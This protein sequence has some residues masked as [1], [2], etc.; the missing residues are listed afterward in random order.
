MPVSATGEAAAWCRSSAMR[1]MAE[2]AAVAPAPIGLRCDRSRTPRPVLGLHREITMM[3]IDSPGSG[4][5]EFPLRVGAARGSGRCHPRHPSPLAVYALG[6]A[7]AVIHY[8]VAPR[9]LLDAMKPP[10]Y[11][12]AGSHYWAIGRTIQLA[13]GGR[14]A[15]CFVECGTRG[16]AAIPCAEHEIP[17]R[18]LP[19]AGEAIGRDA[20]LGCFL[21]SKLAS[22]GHAE[23]RSSL[24]LLMATPQSEAALSAR[25]RRPS[26]GFSISGLAGHR[27]SMEVLLSPAIGCTGSVTSVY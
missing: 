23:P 22:L 6:T 8:L 2:R 19:S 14:R 20:P 13:R 18:I 25:R 12:E 10:Y 26:L 17:L 1:S 4:L 3:P 9:E 11:S 16:R 21:V 27:G 24:V 7:D 15:V 5:P